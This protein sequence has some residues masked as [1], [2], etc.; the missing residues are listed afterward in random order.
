MDLN[1]ISI[2]GYLGGDAKTSS[3]NGGTQV[4][5]F[6]VATNKSWKDDNSG[7][8]KS[9]SQWHNIVGYGDW[10]ASLAARLVKGAH[11][12]VQGE[13]VTREYERTVEVTVGK[14][15]VEAKVMQLAVEIRPDKI[16][17]LDRKPDTESVSDEAQNG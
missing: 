15:K 4:T 7:D 5:K 10:P 17:L 3:T 16:S 2:I 13:L 6:S 14:K 1:Q 8:W 11:V 12:F 9:K